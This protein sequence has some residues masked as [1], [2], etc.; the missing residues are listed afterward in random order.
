MD[1][2]VGQ[3]PKDL[4]TN[5][6]LIP[7]LSVLPAE[8]V[9]KSLVAYDLPSSFGLPEVNCNLSVNPRSRGGF[10]RGAV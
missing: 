8:R 1:L 2:E 5:V 3:L 4:S 6:A 9:R 7:D 10:E